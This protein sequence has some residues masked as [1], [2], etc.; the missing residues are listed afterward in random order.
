MDN[1]S[2]FRIKDDGDSLHGGADDASFCTGNA[3]NRS[4]TESS[5]GDS[6]HSSG[7]LTPLFQ[8]ST[9]NAPDETTDKTTVVFQNTLDKSSLGDSNHSSGELTPLFQK[10]TGNAPDETT[11]KTTVVFQNTPECFTNVELKD[12]L[13]QYGFKG[14][15][16]IIY[17]PISYKTGQGFG[18]AFVNF[19]SHELAVAIL[20]FFDGFSA[21][22]V[23]TQRVCATEWSKSLQGTSALIERYAN[24][25]LMQGDLPDSYKPMYLVNGEQVQFPSPPRCMRK[26]PR[27]KRSRH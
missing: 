8:K 5:L 25:P 7:E 1:L 20:D 24:S 10:S 14:C 19:V 3:S 17:L 21:W 9:G 2:P 26:K 18:Y 4:S 16:D 22:G 12:L 6:N 15:F 23:E 11:D 13:D 27:S